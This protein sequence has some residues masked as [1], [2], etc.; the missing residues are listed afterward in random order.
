MPIRNMFVRPQMLSTIDGLAP[1]DYNVLAFS[2][3]NDLEF[4]NPKVLEPYLS[5]ATR[6]TLAPHGK[7]TVDVDLIERSEP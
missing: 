3:A 2:S 6:V 7:A 1:G 4:R 5:Q